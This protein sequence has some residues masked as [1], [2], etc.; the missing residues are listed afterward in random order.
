MSRSPTVRLGGYVTAVGA[1]RGR[2]PPER[3]NVAN[4]PAWNRRHVNSA[5]QED[6]TMHVRPDR[7]L[8]LIAVAAIV[9]L[10]PAGPVPAQQPR[11]GGELVFVVGSEMPSYD[12]H[13]EE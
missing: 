4:A 10:W 7:V 11:P 8:V 9:A 13:R 1:T 3:A 5:P 2:P 6:R 12:G